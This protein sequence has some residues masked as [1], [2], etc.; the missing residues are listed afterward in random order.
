MK[1]AIG[2]VIW[3][4]KG[5]TWEHGPVGVP[6][7][8]ARR[9]PQ[10]RPVTIPVW[11]TSMVQPIGIEARRVGTPRLDLLDLAGTGGPAGFLGQLGRVGLPDDPL[12][13]ACRTG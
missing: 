11:S 1:E 9:H 3:S 8:A 6:P 4:S 13:L 10:R 2:P 12:G 5:S 7:T